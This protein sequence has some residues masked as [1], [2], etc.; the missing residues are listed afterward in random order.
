MCCGPVHAMCVLISNVCLT[1]CLTIVTTRGGP[2]EFGNDPCRVSVLEF[3]SEVDVECRSNLKMAAL[4]FLFVSLSE[5]AVVVVMARM[6][7]DSVYKC[8]STCK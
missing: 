7:D 2:H 5:I 4:K 6:I 8:T 3:Q 1:A